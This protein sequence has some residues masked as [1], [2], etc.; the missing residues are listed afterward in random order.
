MD[1]GNRRLIGL[2]IIL[3]G[4]AL[5]LDQFGIGGINFGNLIGTFW[6]LVLIGLGLAAL[7]RNSRVIGWG[8]VVL[9][10]AFQFS[11]LFDWNV[12]SLVWPLLIIFVGA[13]M[14]LRDRRPNAKMP[15]HQF[16]SYQS[17][18]QFSQNSKLDELVMFSGMEKKI[19]NED[20][21]GGSLT[22]IFGGIDLDIREVSLPASGAQIEVTTAF[23][24]VK[25]L[26]S[27]RYRVVSDGL[28]LFGGWKVITPTNSDQTKPVL[29]IS[30]VS[31][32]GGVEI[33]S[34]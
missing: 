9:G 27:D 31:I 5:L 30:G 21:Q 23:G 29:K 34:A 24:A 10:A 19:A 18:P 1:E 7:S 2:I 25:V 16:N 26:V 13:R 22:C 8:L 14:F 11:E 6:P 28:P 20:F 33:V 12:W 3:L 32:F 4:G 17:T 15:D